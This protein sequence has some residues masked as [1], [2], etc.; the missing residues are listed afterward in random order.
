MATCPSCSTETAPGW[1]WCGICHANLVNPAI[2]RLASPGKRFA[3]YF[4]DGMIP[5]VAFILILAIAGAS[6]A[7]GADQGG[8]TAGTV[9]GLLLLVA[10]MV[11]ALTLFS[12]GTTP[13]KRMLGMSV[14][15]EDGNRAGFF[16]MLIREWIGK[17][18]SAMILSL[19]F[20][21]VLFN[22]DNQGWHDKLVSTY[23]VE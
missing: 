23:V 6:Q 21:W 1:R 10:Y 7:A 14:I 20:L 15:R 13:G 4:L 18:I 16:T 17:T 3:A 11:W 5:M 12:R 2:G 22:R 19:G 8:G 9:V